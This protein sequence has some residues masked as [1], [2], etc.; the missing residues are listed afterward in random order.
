MSNLLTTNSGVYAIGCLA[1]V[2]ALGWLFAFSLVEARIGLLLAGAAGIVGANPLIG[3]EAEINRTL[4]RK[5]E[6]I[7]KNR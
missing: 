5:G 3:F 7:E 1:P 4:L 2:F 6:G